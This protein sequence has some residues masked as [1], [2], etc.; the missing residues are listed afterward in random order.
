MVMTFQCLT[1]LTAQH[2]AQ[3]INRE[4]KLT[5]LSGLQT[6]SSSSKKPWGIWVYKKKPDYLNWT[7][8]RPSCCYSAC[9]CDT[10]CLF[11][12]TNT[13][14]AVNISR[15]I[16]IYTLLYC[17]PWTCGGLLAVRYEVVLHL[18][19]ILKI[20]LVQSPH[21][22][23]ALRLRDDVMGSPEWEGPDGGTKVYD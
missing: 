20:R 10:L 1:Y 23:V 7:G 21:V 6:C 4:G 22:G 12:N 14:V 8:E 5:C 16:W 11:K 13:G 17:I 3:L 2:N 19:A 18:T 15:C 9:N